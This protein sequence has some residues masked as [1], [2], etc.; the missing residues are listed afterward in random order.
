MSACRRARARVCMC[1]RIYARARAGPYVAWVWVGE[2]VIVGGGWGWGEE[3]WVREGV[4]M[5]EGG[6]R[7]R[8]RSCMCVCWAGGRYPFL[9]G[10][11]KKCF[12]HVF[13]FVCL[14]S[15]CE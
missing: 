14:H 3:G 9:A 11:Y 7:V 6:T 2:M 1:V 13:I 10:V 8:E 12:V 5:R 15:G 4:L